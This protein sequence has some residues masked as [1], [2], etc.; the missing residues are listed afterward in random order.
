[1]R[2]ATL[3]ANDSLHHSSIKVYLSAVR[4]LHIDNGLPDPLVNCLQLQRLLR[5]IKRVQDSSPSKRLPITIDLLKVIQRS[6]DL[7][8]RDHVMFWAACYIGLF[9]FL[10]AGEFTTNPP[11]DSSI[12]LAVSD[13]QADALVDPSCFKIHIK[14]SKTD[15]F[16]MCCDI[17]VGRGNSV[18]CPVVAIGNFLALRGPFARATVLLCGWSP[19]NPTVVIIYSA[20]YPTLCGLSWLILRPQLPD[21][22][23]HCSCC[24]G[25]P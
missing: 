21:W 4:S 16:C 13:V 5:G 14:C 25:N 12:H 1:M 2:F 6:L 3:L 11:F 7:N 24:L 20:V 15:P 18:I 8:S 10:C 22:C 23:N 19:L 9:G 17:Y